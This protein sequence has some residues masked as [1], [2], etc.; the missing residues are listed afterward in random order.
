M[1]Q[2]AVQQALELA[3]QHHFAGRLTDAEGIYRQVLAQ[4]PNHPDALHLLGVIADQVGKHEMAVNLIERAIAVCPSIGEYHCNLGL[5]LAAQGRNDDATAAYRRAI[6]LEPANAAA[7]N[8]LGVAHAVRSQ[9]DDAITAY[10]RAIQLQPGYADAH[11]NLGLALAA[12]GHAAAA[13][14]QYHRALQCQPDHPGVLNNLGIAL[15][16]RGQFAEA[17]AALR[18]ALQLQPDHVD[19]CNNLGAAF[20]HLSEPKEAIAAYRR[21]IQIR[22]DRP[23]AHNNL[24]VALSHEGNLDEA[25]TE[26]RHAIR[27][28]PGYVEAHNNLGNL[29]SRKV[30]FD[31]AIASYQRALELRP[32]YAEARNNL[33]LALKD[34]GRPDEAVASYRAALRLSPADAG[35]HA[36]LIL[37]LHYLPDITPQDIRD[38]HARWRSIHARFATKDLPHENDRSPAR[39]LRIGYVSADF[40]DHVVG[41]TLL[42]VFEK[43]DRENFDL[44][45]YSGTTPSDE[46]AKRFHTRATQWR[47]TAALSDE[48]LAAL[49]REDRIDILIDL[50]LH[51][52]GSRL[53]AFARKPAPV[54][55]SWLGYPGS[56]GL[57]TID[58]RI[59]DPWLEPETT[60]THDTP[61]QPLRLP[62]CWCCYAPPEDSPSPGP[63][64]AATSGTITF[65]SFNNAAKISPRVLHLWAE[66]LNRVPGSRLLLLS[67]GSDLDRARTILG[68]SGISADRIE[69]LGFYAPHMPASRDTRPL[70]YLRRYQRIDIALDPSPYNGMTTTCDALWMGV[71]LVALIG[72]S[73]MARASYSLLTAIGLPEFAAPTE[74]DYLRIAADLAHDLPRLTALRATLR[75]KMKASPLLDTAT[76]T[77]HLEAAYRTAWQ[78]WCATHHLAKG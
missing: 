13:V 28:R 60:A 55:I 53:G 76:F 3:I 73:S 14:A 19:A 36:N 65:G 52:A 45:C 56:T 12:Q 49:I 47:E 16:H 10:H 51:T 57:D 27:I 40:R 74:H 46:I 32:D 20:M 17:I 18:R 62:D 21:V 72:G 4:Q 44:F 64:P 9:F 31:E 58:Y 77:R 6:Q 8:N 41:R 48:K 5:A 29:L 1:P 33:G 67:K 2:P 24:G 59:T 39:R 63:L 50:A 38:E 15:T 43:H 69:L 26:Y 11:N 78:T 75:G 23:E 35:T 42:P 37:G 70:E 7:F 34:C 61:E 71:P 30:R 66:I 54:Q 68:E 22:P 25:E